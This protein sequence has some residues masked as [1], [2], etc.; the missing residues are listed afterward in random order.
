MTTQTPGF[1]EMELCRTMA[2]NTKLQ[3][4]L[5]TMRNIH[6]FYAKVLAFQS[7]RCIANQKTTTNVRNI[8]AENQRRMQQ[9]LDDY[10][11]NCR[12]MIEINSYMNNEYDP[13]NDIVLAAY[14]QAYETKKTNLWQR[15]KNAFATHQK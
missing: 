8:I 7:N 14:E 10:L 2:E 15:I 12:Y 9:L 5:N 1:Y 6:S 4:A 3:N 13:Q 11:G